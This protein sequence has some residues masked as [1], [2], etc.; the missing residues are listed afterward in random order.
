MATMGESPS[1]ASF[2]RL[3]ARWEH[4]YRRLRPAW[5]RVDVEGAAIA[6]Q[7]PEARIRDHDLDP[8]AARV[9]VVPL[10]DV[11]VAGERHREAEADAALVQALL[12]RPQ[13]EATRLRIN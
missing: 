7:S 4:V 8:E 3:L 1:R 13:P 11:G 10:E 5:Q 9:V 12:A 6:E 2:P